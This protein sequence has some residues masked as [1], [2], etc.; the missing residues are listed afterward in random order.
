MSLTTDGVL[1]VI[2]LGAFAGGLAVAG[3][4]L[5]VSFLAVGGLGTLAFEAVAFGHSEAVRRY[6]ERPSVQAGTL[7]GA[8]GL[9]GV[10]IAVAPSRILSA[11][12]GAVV[13]YL[14]FLSFVLA[15]RS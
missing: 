15:T 12:I 2:A 1:A 3:A 6:W 9:V 10:G 8:F 14:L 11:G 5:S 4:P 13:T 7:A